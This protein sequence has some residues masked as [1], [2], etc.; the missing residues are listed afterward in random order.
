[1]LPNASESEPAV[2]PALH[3]R[4]PAGPDAGRR[5]HREADVLVQ[6]RGQALGVG[7]LAALDVAGEQ[8]P[9]GGGR[10]GVALPRLAVLGQVLPQPGPRALQRG[11]HRRLRRL[12]Q[13]RG[14]LR[15]AAED[16]AQH[17]HGPRQRREVLDRGDERQL[18]GLPG[19]RHVLRALAPVGQLLEQLVGIGLQ[20][21][22]LAVSRSAAAGACRARRGRRSSRS[23]TATREPTRGPRTSRAGA[24]RAG[25]PPG[26]GPRPP[27]TT[28]AGGSSGRAVR[29]GAA[30]R[31]R[32]RPARRAAG[33]R[34]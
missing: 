16:V 24:T 21:G 9:L 11:V 19:E 31:G 30:R 18:D 12:E 14:L 15:R 13:P 8:L 10:L 2:D 4:A 7:A 5:R 29:G 20:P 1:M 26:R 32:R 33:G 27:R 25:T 6:E 17:E 23:G 34:R 3:D 22:D 28:R